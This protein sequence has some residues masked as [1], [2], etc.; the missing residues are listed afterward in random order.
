[1]AYGLNSYG[2]D[3]P[4]LADIISDTKDTF[5]E[6]FVGQ[7]INVAE[8]SVLDK[9]ITIFADRESTLWELQ[10]DIYY[11]QT[12]AGAENIYLDDI[13]SKRGV[14]RN[15]ATAAS[16]NIQVTLSSLASYTD[17]YS[18]GNF[19]ILNDTFTNTEDFTVAGNIFAHKIT[20][21]NITANTTYTFTILNTTTETTSSITA[22]TA[23][24]L[25]GS[26]A[27]NT[28]YQTIK[29]FI[30]DNT[31]ES[32][33]DLIQIDTINGIL[34]IG[35]DTNYNLSGLNTL[36]DFKT[37]PVIGQRTIQIEMKAN[38]V[39]YNPI[40]AG[41]V[42]SISPEPTGYVSV[43]NISDFST[44]SDVESDSE[45]RA[46]A[47]STS[48]SGAAAT[49]SAII[50][51]LLDVE[52]VQKVKL[53]PNPTSSA[54]VEGVPAYQM[55]IVVYG[56]TTA[57]IA[58]AIYDLIGVNIQ[59]YGTTA[60]TITTGDSDTQIIYHTKAS[61]KQLSVRVT[62]T[63]SNNRALSDTEKDAI[64]YGITTLADEFTISSTVY[65][66]QLTTA[67]S[68]SVSS[69]RFLSLIVETKDKDALDTAYTVSNVVPAYTELCSVSSD[70]ITFVQ[71]T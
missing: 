40:Y 24:T 32:N 55:M 36:V 63:T 54:S 22:S 44:G 25:V 52:G 14:F 46:R 66:F 39:G 57:G 19:S 5:T 12:L 31:I 45:Y 53:Y 28:F 38:D 58:Q 11:S 15:A 56:G 34:Y 69:S 43:K 61:E 42:T 51:G 68:S 50:S 23:T 59:T 62:Y 17:N 2:F 71:S 8:N 10:E 47:D 9:I 33:E 60:Y 18:A 6:T 16:G 30:V 37:T 1:M 27:L 65:N 64:I 20:N 3:R 49:R 41:T 4:T 67:V 48:V 35:Y 29:D 7:N 26:T 70:D 13:L 21:T